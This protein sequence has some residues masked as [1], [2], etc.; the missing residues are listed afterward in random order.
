MERLTKRNEKGIAYLKLCDNLPKS[1]QEIEGSKQVL[2]T[3]YETWQ[4]LAKYEDL[5]EQCLLLVLPCRV[6]DT[7]YRLV[8]KLYKDIQKQIIDELII[9]DYGIFYK[10]TKGTTWS[11]STIGKTVFLT[12][13]QAE[14]KS[15]E[16]QEGES[17]KNE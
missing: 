7:V 1:K 17:D 10:T 4:K 9:R 2:E 14:Q 5:E 6:G 16:L 8:P 11:L 15:K 13:E 3:L 12:R